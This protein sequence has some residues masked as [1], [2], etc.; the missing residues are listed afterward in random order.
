MITKPT[1]R[2]KGMQEG[3]TTS[4]FCKKLEPFASEPRFFFLTWSVGHVWFRFSYPPGFVVI[5]LS[6]SSFSLAMA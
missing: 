5:V 2:V 1:F 3:L 6:V 4:H